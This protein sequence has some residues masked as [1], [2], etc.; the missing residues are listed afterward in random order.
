MPISVACTCGKKLTVK[1]E[2]AGKKVRCPA[3]Q[4]I[5]KIPVPESPEEDGEFPDL[6]DEEDLAPPTRSRST[7][8]KSKD[9]KLKSSDSRGAGT[10]WWII[11]AVLFCVGLVGSGSYYLW[12]R[13]GDDS[14][15]IDLTQHDFGPASP[16]GKVF[17]PTL[18]GELERMTK[19]QL[20]AQGT[21]LSAGDLRRQVAQSVMGIRKE[22]PELFCVSPDEEQS[23]IAGTFPRETAQKEFAEALKSILGTS[24]EVPEIVTFHRKAAEANTASAARLRVLTTIIL[25]KI[26]KE[27][28]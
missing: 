28:T 16:A 17:S 4:T 2:S 20:K 18:I 11:G 23:F 6:E 1:D 14:A 21:E 9:R 12:A 25:A 5:L 26:L 24:V 3:C 7:K 13:G 19:E 8:S 10:K 15:T 27:L 22:S